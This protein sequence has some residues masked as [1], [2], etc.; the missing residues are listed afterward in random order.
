MPSPVRHPK[1]D[2][3][4]IRLFIG[5]KQT[6][7]TLRTVDR[8]EAREAAAK[9]TKAMKLARQEA[10][11]PEW[12]I[13]ATRGIRKPKH[14]AA[15]ERILG[16]L[17]KASTGEGLSV[18]TIA[19]TFEAHIEDLKARCRAAS[20]IKNA[21]ASSGDLLDS[22]GPKRAGAPISTLSVREIEAWIARERAA[23]LAIASVK[24]K[25]TPLRAAVESAIRRG[26]CVL[27]PFKSIRWADSGEQR[28]EYRAFTADEVKAL[29][30]VADADW[31]TVILL[32]ALAGLRIGDAASRTWGE[33][34]LDAGWLTFRVTKTK[35]VE[36]LPLHHD[37]LAHL[38]TLPQ[39]VA[40]AP[41]CPGLWGV[42][43]SSISRRFARVMKAAGI[44][45]TAGGKTEGKGVR[46]FN[47]GFHM[48]RRFYVSAM[49]NAGVSRELRMKLAGHTTDAAHDVYT[50]LEAQLL[51]EANS[52]IS[53]G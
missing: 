12:C 17:L 14:R 13:S 7:R 15:I 18:P 29:L 10:L 11:T 9:I 4:F 19:A 35:R 1:T 51:R 40:K 2:F 27:N 52:R 31:K 6:M 5:P 3:W 47:L 23:G 39:G 37:L 43:S 25:A 49:A 33:V 32:G 24:S 53:L 34:D 45:R 21:I 16:D 36:R 41:L 48:L 22:I 30:A 42:D 20:S 28:A 44:V 46:R 50:E 26:E 38:R 8:D